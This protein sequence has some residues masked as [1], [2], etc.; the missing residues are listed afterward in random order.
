M[1]IRL[2]LEL[3]LRAVNINKVNLL[4]RVRSKGS[5]SNELVKLCVVVLV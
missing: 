2:N 3:I 4:L 5:L 1:L